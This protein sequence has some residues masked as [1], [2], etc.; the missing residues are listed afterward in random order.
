M[1]RRKRKRLKREYG[2]KNGKQGKR[3]K[4]LFLKEILALVQPYEINRI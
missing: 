4:I 3:K 2:K 1:R